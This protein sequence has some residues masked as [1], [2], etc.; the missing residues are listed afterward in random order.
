MSRRSE[1]T[2]AWL[3]DGP[4]LV[5]LC[6][7]YPDEWQTVARELAEATAGGD[8]DALA[9]SLAH[10]VA[11]SPGRARTHRV[12][13]AEE[14]RRQMALAA[15]RQATVT[16]ATGVSSGTLRFNLVNGFLA[17]RLLFARDLRRKPASLTAFRLVWP[18]LT[19][20]RYLMP[21]VRPKGIYCFYSGRF[22]KELKVLIAGRPCLEIAAGD[23]TL[24]RFLAAAGVEITA[25]D[26][27]SWSTAVR[28]PDDVQHQD[29]VRALRI[30]EPK[31]VLCSWPPTGNV[32]ERHV[33]STASVE[34]YIVIGT[35]QEIGSGNW[36]DYRS[37]HDFELSDDARLSRL[38]L[39]PE[40]DPAVYVFRRRT[41]R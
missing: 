13:L 5:E 4:T 35:H 28:Y 31:V 32:F 20:R 30:R 3:R 6:T 19:Q 26:D 39:P 18:M 33:F 14:I 7:A 2:L 9:T 40:L 36:A 25:T 38:V 16:A 29:A 23:G 41:G 8:L 12:L 17:Q 27:F 37:Q 11:S 21:L 24:S 1:Q 22:I 10:P 15:L 34:L